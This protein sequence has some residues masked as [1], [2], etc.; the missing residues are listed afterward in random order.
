M[1]LDRADC[2]TYVLPNWHCWGCFLWAGGQSQA[3]YLQALFV[4]T[5][6]VT[7]AVGAS[8]VAKYCLQRQWHPAGTNYSFPRPLCAQQIWHHLR[9]SQMCLEQ[10]LIGACNAQS[11]SHLCLLFTYILHA[12][13]PRTHKKQHSHLHRHQ[14]LSPSSSSTNTCCPKLN[15]PPT[16]TIT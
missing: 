14:P 5:G 6:A 2:S 16:S 9:T 3:V 12:E 7:I 15:I 11:Q 10:R 13:I 8:T 1:I 4:D